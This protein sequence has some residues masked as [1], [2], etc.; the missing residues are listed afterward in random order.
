M[1][2][3]VSLAEAPA[4][5]RTRRTDWSDER[6]LTYAKEI[7][8]KYLTRDTHLDVSIVLR[9]PGFD[10]TQE[11]SWPEHASEVDFP[12]MVK[13]GLDGGLLSCSSVRGH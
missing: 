3:L 1:T 5:E 13:G 6:L 10:I 11:H 12:R 7:H 4:E 9:R 8:A 2:A